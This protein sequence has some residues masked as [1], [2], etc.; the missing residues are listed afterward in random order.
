VVR[1]DAGSMHSTNDSRAR[2]SAPAYPRRRLF[3]NGPHRGLAVHL[4]VCFRRF[5]IRG[6]ELQILLLHERHELVEV[7]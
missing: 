7:L 3:A 1:L 5:L 2:R 4:L 6:S